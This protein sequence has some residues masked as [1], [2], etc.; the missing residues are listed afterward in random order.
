MPAPVA[1]AI[2][3][4]DEQLLR[5]RAPAAAA[6]YLG[7][8]GAMVLFLFQGVR[9]W[10]TFLLLPVAV[11]VGIAAA[12]TAMTGRLERSRVWIAVACNFGVMLIY[13]RV[14][15]PLVLPPGIAALIAM[16]VLTHPTLRAWWLVVAV[17]S[18]GPLTAWWLEEVGVFATTSVSDGQRLV[19]G[20]TMVDLPSGLV[21]LGLV[22]YILSL[23]GVAALFGRRVANAHHENRHRLAVQA[24]HLRRLLGGKVEQ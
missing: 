9:D 11:T 21:E 12:L 3:R 20:S 22:F 10:T 14:L 16:I 7:I 18:L 23:L 1:A 17:M 2:R 8:V 19:L 13:S 4:D 24:W 5:T 15:G 6:S